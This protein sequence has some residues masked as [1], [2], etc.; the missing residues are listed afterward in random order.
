MQ[1]LKK[2]QLPT[3]PL[4]AL[5]PVRHV[6]N[7]PQVIQVAVSAQVTHVENAPQVKQVAE[8]VQTWQVAKSLQNWQVADPVQPTQGPVTHDVQEGSHMLLQDG[9]QKL[10]FS[11][12]LV[13]HALSPQTM[14]W[15]VVQV[16]HPPLSQLTQDAF[17]RTP[18][19]T[20]MS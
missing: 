19:A 5:H 6:D 3:H 9:S 11:H 13:L 14:H 10:Q 16:M 1:V 8:P 7:V 4:K 2:L 17:P 18:A 15:D 20:Q 12:V